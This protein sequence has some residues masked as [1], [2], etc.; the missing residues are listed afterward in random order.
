VPTVLRGDI[1]RL[2]RRQRFGATSLKWPVVSLI[3]LLGITSQ[4]SWIYRD[5]LLQR[6]PVIRPYLEQ[7]CSKLSC[8]LEKSLSMGNIEL[9]AREVREHPLY[10]NALLINATL[11]NRS[12]GVAKYPL[13]QLG[14]YDHAGIVIGIR[15]FQPREYLD[16][17]IDIEHGMPPARNL[18]VVLELANVNTK[19]DGFE[20]AFF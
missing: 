6:F 15:R 9:I 2:T 10:K 11:I 16:A 17:S 18:Y 8:H 12:A 13:I 4:V 3:A 1:D 20:F 19:A 7:W 14:I 5:I